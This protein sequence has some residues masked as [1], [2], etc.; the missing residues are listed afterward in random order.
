MQSTLLYVLA[1]GFSAL[2]DATF[3]SPKAGD[4]WSKGTSQ[5]ISWDS[6]SLSSGKCDIQLV[7]SGAK[8][9]STI[10]SEIALQV[11]N[12]GSY[13]WTPSSSISA[14]EA[15]IIIVDSKKTMIISGVFT[16]TSGSIGASNFGHDSGSHKS[17]P[18]D[19]LP[20]KSNHTKTYESKSHETKTKETKTHE[21][22]TE[23]KGGETVST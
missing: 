14:S 13:S 15:E 4:E 22:K 23:T 17:K 16:F 5:S 11:D 12:T 21:T 20:S 19:Y 9:T 18:Y 8:D 2:A 1:L 3:S 7:P 10:I 6:S